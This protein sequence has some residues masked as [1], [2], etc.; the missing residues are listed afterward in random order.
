MIDIEYRLSHKL[1]LP[2]HVRIEY[3]AIV[4]ESHILSFLPSS[5]GKNTDDLIDFSFTDLLV[6]R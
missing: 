2:Q 5:F 6:G 1:I 3:G 4:Q